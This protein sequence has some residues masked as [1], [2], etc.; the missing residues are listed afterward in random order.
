MVAFAL[1]H[2]QKQDSPSSSPQVS[3]DRGL[4]VGQG[5]GPGQGL[6]KGPWEM[7]SARYPVLAKCDPYL[8]HPF[9]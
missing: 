6:Y 8:I 3:H 1:N 2:T 7:T 5:P 9:S 4:L